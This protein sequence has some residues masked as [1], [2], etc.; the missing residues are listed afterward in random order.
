MNKLTSPLGPVADSSWP[1]TLVHR[2]I[3]VCIANPQSPAIKDDSGITLSYQQMLDRI[4][5]IAEV[6]TKT[7]IASKPIIG[8]YQEKT[9]DSICSLLAVMHVG[10][11]YLPLDPGAPIERLVCIVADCSPSIIIID[12]STANK[13]NGLGAGMASIINCSSVPAST[14]KVVPIKAKADD[15]G[16]IFYT[17]G[18]TGTPKGIPIS[19]R[20]L[21]NEVEFSA[22]TYNFGVENVLQQ[23]SP[24][25]DMSLTQAFAA[26][27]FG[28]YLYVCPSRLH[29]DSV[30]QAALIASEQITL[31]GGTPSEYLSWIQVGFADL[32]KSPW[33]VAI[34]GGE[35]IKE[36]LLEAFR[37]LGNEKLHLFN[38]YGPTEV[39]CS[40]TR[41]EVDYNDSTLLTRG[42]MTVGKSAPNANFYIANR[43]LQPVP[44]GFAGEVIIGGAGIALGYFN[45]TEETS[46][47]FLENKFATPEERAR[48]WTSIHRTGD[49]GKMMPDRSLQLLGRIEGDRQIKL[50][51][52]RIDLDEIECAISTIRGVADV[53]V[54]YRQLDVEGSDYI[55]AHVVVSDPELQS[56]DHLRQAIDR[57]PLAPQMRPSIVVLDNEL[58]RG[59]TGKID[60]RA[61]AQLNISSAENSVVGGSAPEMEYMREVWSRVIAPEV[62]SRHEISTATDF[63][64]V[65]GNSLLLV[66]LQRRLEVTYDVRVSLL[67]LFEASTLGRMTSLVKNSS[68]TGDAM[69][70]WD[71]E[72]EPVGVRPSADTPI[73]IA[74]AV[75][76]LTGVTG[77]LGREIL[78]QLVNNPEVQEIHC[79]AVR[80]PERLSG[81]S[82]KVR[83]YAGDLSALSL[84]LS[85]RDAQTIFAK[86][87][88][89]I[90]NG[91]NV[92]HLKHYRSLRA[93]NVGST[94]ELVR[95]AT[96]RLVP[97]HF[98][99]TAGVALYWVAHL[100]TNTNASVS[101]PQRSE[102]KF[103]EI[104]VSDFPPPP[105]GVEGYTSSKWAAER[106]LER[107]HAQFGLPVFVHR[108]SNISRTDVPKLDLFRNLLQFCGRLNA[109]PVSDTL[110]GYLNLVPV[111]ACARGILGEALRNQEEGGGE[112][113]VRFWH[114]IGDVNLTFEDL[115]DYVAENRGLPLQ[116][117]KSVPLKEWTEMAVRVGMHPT[118]A[119]YFNAAESGGP[120]NYPLLVPG[121]A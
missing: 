57:L 94:R 42:S 21:R 63:F 99:S 102:L 103:G 113:K 43:F 93:E 65:G 92:S 3:D 1:D 37:T 60:R 89:I 36:S 77:H 54:S 9:A 62:F 114:R 91:A 50:R 4:L 82:N 7:S 47:R 55:V 108:P 16:V 34:S 78:D 83:V 48:K 24:S 96:P 117:V 120:I 5:S 73:P 18:T 45:R 76:V 30:A 75:V 109:V 56:A 8:V 51:G 2:V 38:S 33:K 59:R 44:V 121:G 53:A 46:T 20:S 66:D 14:S 26:L 23:S 17:S 32:R 115:R 31:T 71:A 88:V 104:S 105:H 86:A 110:R 10:A 27:A 74:P 85:S 12:G 19:H 67:Q 90:H 107:A 98:V 68:D 13:V 22:Q 39:T 116:D 41:R 84:G 35:P 15:A 58:P 101:T 81:L 119:S 100:N 106:L 70:D 72:T 28:G 87:T 61:V 6:L 52:I 25:F 69:I 80:Q 118:V 95:L 49:L 112:K 111:E 11:T 40:A 97:L 79:I 64:H 29:A